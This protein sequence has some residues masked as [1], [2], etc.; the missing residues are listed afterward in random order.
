MIRKILFVPVILSL[1][2]FAAMAVTPGQDS[3]REMESRVKTL[4]RETTTVNFVSREQNLHDNASSFAT[5]TAFEEYAK[6]MR[7]SELYARVHDE[8]KV[9][10]GQNVYIRTT[11]ADSSGKSSYTG[12]F[13]MIIIG[14]K[15]TETVPYKFDMV[16]ER[17]LFGG[18]K[19]SS[20]AF[21]EKERNL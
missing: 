19:I 8:R 1:G 21:S 14:S 16:L 13:N 17:G 4:V 6:N 20:V 5:N 10:E 7:E 9:V 3:D 18:A 15:G 11:G 12:S 2:A